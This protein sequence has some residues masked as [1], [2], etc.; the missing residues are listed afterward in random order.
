M[1]SAS[2]TLEH[3]LECI[4]ASAAAAA[5][6]QV[7]LPPHLVLSQLL[8][9]HTMRRV[10]HHQV[11]LLLWVQREDCLRLPTSAAMR[12]HIAVA[13]TLVSSKGVNLPLVQQPISDQLLDHQHQ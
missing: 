13:C 5:A 1:L 12:Q 7:L 8:A 6:M 10:P 2:Y 3:L 4:A 11:V 9:V